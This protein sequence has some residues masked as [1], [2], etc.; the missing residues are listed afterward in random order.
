VGAYSFSLDRGLVQAILDVLPLGVFVETGTFEGDSV[1][2][3]ADLFAEAHTIEL[4]AEYA[5]RSRQ[6]FEQVPTVHVHAGRSADVLRDI[7][8]RLEDASVLFWLDA[9]WCDADQTAGHTAQSPLLDE[10]EAIGCLGPTDVLLIDDARLY[11][12]PPPEPHDLADWPRF[13]SVAQALAR[14]SDQHALSVVNDVIVYVPP[15]AAEAVN[16]WAR[17]KGEDLLV[18]LDRLRAL[19]KERPSLQAVVAEQH[20]EID[21][22][23][24]TAEERLSLIGELTEAAD[25]RLRVIEKLTSELERQTG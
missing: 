22:L 2:A 8:P 20:A 25:D 1:A 12:S 18:L 7:R 5:S 4:S 10:L 14:L 24:K 21:A 16:A 13:Q 9:H 19:E 23:T 17:A 3:V 6:R 15:K 11:L